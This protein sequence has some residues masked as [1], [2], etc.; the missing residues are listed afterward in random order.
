MSSARKIQDEG[1]G[2]VGSS[3]FGDISPPFTLTRSRSSTPLTSAQAAVPLVS[4]SR[5]AAALAS[6]SCSCSRN[7]GSVT[8][9]SRIALRS[10]EE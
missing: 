8:G 10:R 6:S 9:T 5:T 4:C 1:F 7:L 3:S 2:E